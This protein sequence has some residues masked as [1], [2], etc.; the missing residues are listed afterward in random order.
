MAMV[1]KSVLIERSS[2]Q[3]FDLVDRVEDYPKFL[4]W[5]SQ[6][7]CEFRDEQKTVATLH[8]NYR[9]VT[10]HFTTENDKESPQWM[11][12]HLVDGP[13]RRLEGLWRFKP[14]ADYACKIEFQLSY[15]FSSKMFEKVIGPVFS[16]IANTFVDAFVKRANEVHGLPNA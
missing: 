11:R 4:P 1:K 6:T 10:S 3:M 9:N 5:C 12:I 13:F 16:Q 14:L 2:Q 15:E 8:I 7:R